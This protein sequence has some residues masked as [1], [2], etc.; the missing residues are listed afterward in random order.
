MSGLV[1]IVLMAEVAFIMNRNTPSKF[2]VLLPYNEPLSDD[3]IAALEEYVA[4]TMQE[5]VFDLLE[6]T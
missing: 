6:M 4:S 1:V 2:S 5:R 3:I